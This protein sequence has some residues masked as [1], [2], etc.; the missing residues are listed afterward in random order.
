MSAILNIISA[1]I[2]KEQLPRKQAERIHKGII[3][4]SQEF[5]AQEFKAQEFKTQKTELKRIA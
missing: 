2:Q 3:R 1:H 4:D 5:K